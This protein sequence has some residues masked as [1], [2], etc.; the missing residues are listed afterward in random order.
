MD[1]ASSDESLGD[2]R[3][4]RQEGKA[5]NEPKHTVG[6]KERDIGENW[7][8][9]YKIRVRELARNWHSKEKIT[10]AGSE[11]LCSDSLTTH[12]SV[13]NEDL[14]TTSFFKVL[15]FLLF[16]LAALGFHCCR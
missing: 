16:Y 1:R 12:K 14:L 6:V 2:F 4:T 13:C 11:G 3:N 15:F 9:V 8:S 7:Y 5:L 10:V